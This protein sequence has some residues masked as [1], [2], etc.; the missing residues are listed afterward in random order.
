MG[1]P[2]H[3]WLRNVEMQLLVAVEDSELMAQHARRHWALSD[4]TRTKG[5]GGHGAENDNEICG[6][7]SAFIFTFSYTQPIYLHD[8]VCRD[9]YRSCCE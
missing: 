3:V 7:I 5:T 9:W 2:V 8:D 4:A 6:G 1:H